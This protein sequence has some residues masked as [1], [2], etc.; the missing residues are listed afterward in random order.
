MDQ[1]LETPIVSKNR[2][3]NREMIS[4]RLQN[5]RKCKVSQSPSR[6]DQSIRTVYRFPHKGDPAAE[7]QEFKHLVIF[8][9]ENEMTIKS[10]GG[11]KPE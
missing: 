11:H 5:V 10:R 7:K 2:Y 1:K 9:F 4:N 6:I 3:M 8:K